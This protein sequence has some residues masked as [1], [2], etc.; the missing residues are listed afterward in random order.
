MPHIHTKPGQHDH[1]ISV[2]LVRTDFSEPK[3]MLH[4]H[5]K[6]GTYAQFGGHIEL[7]E[8]PWQSVI[9]E[10]KEEAGY[11]IEQISVLQP[12]N[13]MTA[14]TGAVV[15]PYPAVHSTMGYPSD[16]GHFHTDTTY[17]LITSESPHALPDKGEST[18]IRLFTRAELVAL[19][20]D[21]IDGVTYDTA[22][23]IF[24]EILNNWEAIS[25][26]AFQA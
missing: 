15:H 21:M 19:G 17:A 5:R 7:H 8:T 18:D 4:L 12:R 1:T 24:D 16:K 22:L 9:H 10:L 6:I 26:Q 20:K 2:Y 14:I 25:P 13:R 3:I 11:N 23:Y